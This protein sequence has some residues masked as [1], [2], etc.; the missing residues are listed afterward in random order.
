MNVPFLQDVFSTHTLNA[1]EW[2]V[3]LA[4]A[5]AIVPV[6]EAAK[7]IERRGWFGKMD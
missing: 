3:L 5:P 4:A 7:W 1:T 2:L 6:L